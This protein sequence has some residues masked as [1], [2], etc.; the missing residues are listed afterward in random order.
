[1]R[2]LSPGLRVAD[3]DVSLAFYEALGFEVVG[4]VAETELGQ[5][6]MLKLPDD[7]FVTIELVS[8]MSG[9]QD[10]DL[11]NGM[12]HVAVQVDSMDEAM[13]V[14]REHHVEVG[15]PSS[16]DGTAGFLTVTVKDPDGR[17]IELVQ[18]PPG[19]AAG[20]SADDWK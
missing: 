1:M 2:T 18:W 14:L 16:P 9:G 10:V 4:T 12:S 6:T 17:D 7:E 20:L 15:E 8:S 11:G 13:K 19:H 5:L 3:L